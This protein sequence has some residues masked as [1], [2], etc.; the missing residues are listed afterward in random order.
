VLAWRN[1]V[2]VEQALREESTV[3]VNEAMPISEERES[4]NDQAAPSGLKATVVV[5]SDALRVRMSKLLQNTMFIPRLPE[6]KQDPSLL[7]TQAKDMI[8]SASD[9]T[10]NLKQPRKLYDLIIAT[11]TILPIFED[12]KRKAH[13]QNLWSL[14][15]P[16]DGVLLLIEKGTPLG[17]EAI[18]GARQTLLKNNIIKDHGSLPSFRGTTANV[19]VYQ[20]RAM[21]YVH[22]RSGAF[23][24]RPLQFLSALR[25]TNLL[26][27]NLKS[28]STK[29]RRHP[30]FVCCIPPQLSV[31]H[32][33]HIHRRADCEPPNGGL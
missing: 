17:F 27:A 12:F 19:A 16:E 2:D 14:L 22:C 3:E 32:F 5:G 30:V 15:K 23:P 21:P 28:Y 18:A 20:P 10:E 6:T 29:P 13:I 24:P 25:A 8:D 31:Q 9:A 11:N 1:I 7:F 33:G 26:A 4:S